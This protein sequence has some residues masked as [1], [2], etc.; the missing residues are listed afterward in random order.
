MV[1]NAPEDRLEFVEFVVIQ[2]VIYDESDRHDREHIEAPFLI[3]LSH[4]E[5]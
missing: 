4:I 2:P 1:L 3:E 5:E